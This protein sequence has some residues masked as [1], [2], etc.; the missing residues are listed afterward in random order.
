MIKRL[1]F[2]LALAIISATQMAGA[3]YAS[4]ERVAPLTIFA[5][6]D[7]VRISWRP[8][9]P[10]DL[11]LDAQPALVMLR[12][13]DDATIAP[14]IVALDDAAST[15]NAVDLPVTPVRVLRESRARGQRL[16]VLAL[17]PRFMR[18]GEPRSVHSLDLFVPSTSPLT[19]EQTAL[20]SA[21][22]AA[23]P[24]AIPSRPPA[25]PATSALRVR[26]SQQ[27]LQVIPAATLGASLIAQ[28]A[29][30]RVSRGGTEI[31]VELFDAN[32]DSQWNVADELRF[33]APAPGDR[34]NLTD[35]YWIT[36]QV[37]ARLR[38]Q[39]RAV[40]APVS[41]APTTALQQGV[42]RGVAYYDSRYPG[43]DGDHWFAA[44]LQ[45]EPGV[46]ADSRATMTVTLTT[47]LPPVSGV[48]TFN[49]VAQTEATNA[50]SLTATAGS[51]PGA[52]VSWSAAGISTQSLS[53][54]IGAVNGTPAQLTLAATGQWTEVAIDTVRWQRPVSLAF[55]G[56]G[57]IFSGA[58][59]QNAY[60]LSGA[61]VNYALYDIT[62]AAAPVR[63][64]PASSS[65]FADTLAA[66]TYLL[67]GTGTRFTPTV[68]AYTGASL[69]TGAAAIYI[70]PA[71]LFSALGPLLDLRRAQG[72]SVA[73]VDVRTIYDGWSYGQV[74]PRA[75][76]AF[77]QH[78]VNTWSPAPQAVTLV[79]DG[80]SDPFDYTKRG[81]NNVNLVPP[82]L[83]M[84]DPWLGET[85]CDMC[86]AQLD[87]DEPT[88]DKLPD[89]WFGRL[90]V[91][92]AAE[93]HIVVNKIVGYE[94]A[95]A[96]GAWRGRMVFLAD[97]QDSGG[98]FAAQ[99]EASIAAQPSNIAVSR[100]FFGSD[101]GQ[102]ASA[103]AARSSVLSELSAGAAVVS[104]FGH[105]H[106][107]QW[108]V[109]A[110]S[111]QNNWLLHRS[112][113]PGLAN[114]VRLPVVVSLTCLSSAFQWPSFVGA[115]V[116]ETLLLT[117]GGGAVAVW[118]P[119]G[120]GISYGHDKLQRGFYE[121]LWAPAPPAR[122][123]ERA[124]ALGALTANGVDTLF[125]ESICC[126]EAIYTYV[127]LGDPLT[128]LRVQTAWAT[129]LPVTLR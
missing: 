14:A 22:D 124:V 74:D 49:V 62:D 88:S 104:Y 52:P 9:T 32:G 112:D 99:A 53:A 111:Q 28:P 20:A 15:G 115:T 81:A 47:T 79:G 64:Q 75:I 118:G 40:P 17:A 34:W 25:F 105:A 103:S 102:I 117:P 27:G 67:A 71:E 58:I 18:A 82:Y 84:V 16:V 33:Y 39:S 77:L 100:V 127:L 91:K 41:A 92:S 80:T 120:L 7:G 43:G 96:G 85:A 2:I 78:A 23:L 76:R 61:P 30:I 21:A 101:S 123:V 35:T 56:Q 65:S 89:I 122:G 54:P 69:P 8:A 1:S 109:T 110:L 36:L 97:D 116:D 38:I 42:F 98:D 19:P 86:Y 26:V 68:E 10:A 57:A 121:A 3:G 37:G 90:P 114:G 24:V 45:A 29:N 70:A 83:A 106:Q 113:V 93:L 126:Q 50:R 128:R 119:T 11:A 13:V 48:V 63:V 72:Y 107:Q 125:S 94:T 73:L 129:M 5:E 31:P 46:P 59:G 55:G 95:P 108:A 87:G 51:S 12:A 6:R 66:R 60:Q 4:D 44:A